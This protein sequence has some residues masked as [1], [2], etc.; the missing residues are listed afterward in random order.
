MQKDNNEK[1]LYD[2]YCISNIDN[3]LVNLDFESEDNKSVI[4]FGLIKA[5]DIE[6][7]MAN[8]RQILFEVTDSCNLRCA[9]CGYGDI[10]ED[11]DQRLNKDFPVDSAKT[12][13]N[14][15]FSRF[16]STDNNSIN[17]N[18]FISFYG[19][20]PLLNIRF[21]K[22]II[23]FIETLDVPNLRFM[24]NMTTN[25]V[26]LDRHMEYLVDKK[27]HI[28]I[29]LDGN[30]F[31]HSYRVNH[32][33]NNSFNQVFTNIKLIQKK[34]PDFFNTNI[35]FNTVLHNRNSVSEAYQFIKQE[36]GKVT[37][38]SELNNMGIREEK[39]K[40]FFDLY[41]NKQESLSQS[42][43]HEIINSDLFFNSPQTHYLSIF[44][45]KYSGNVFRTYSELLYNSDVN[46]WIP[47]GTC[48]PFSKKIFITVNGKILPC[49]R[50]GQQFTLGQL[51]RNSVELDFELIA[52]RY[53]SW[54]ETIGKQCAQCYNISSC[55]QC[56]FNIDDLDGSPVCKGFMGKEG[57][58]Q[59]IATQMTYLQENPGLY[60]RI[61]EELIIE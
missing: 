60:K 61:M 19:G 36:F 7:Q 37:S 15:M 16:K 5:S 25:A 57:F 14:Y 55:M 10:Y 35:R 30:K 13:L 56:I 32:L 39:K 59:Y 27:V 17:Y 46:N 58:R 49:E 8:V 41:Q 50:I 33:G 2:N 24:Y 12:F 20:E 44:L 28:L 6:K 18:V 53:N 26:L 1:Y 34:Y 52:D 45:H 3:E 22:D 48:F 40:F 4:S 31:N 47:T 51:T 23:Y 21:I 42:V 54:Y 29:S 43:E 38:I 9:Y 11:H